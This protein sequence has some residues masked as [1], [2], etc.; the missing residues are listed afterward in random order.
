MK[1]DN[2]FTRS[3]KSK[4][5][6]TNSGEPFLDEYN[7]DG[8]DTLIKTGKTNIYEKIQ[9]AAPAQDINYIVQKFIN[10]DPNAL[11]SVHG[12]YGDFSDMPTTYAELFDR[13]RTC[14]D[15]FNALPI[16]LRNEFD[17]NAYEFWKDFGSDRFNSVVSR[18]VDDTNSD[19]APTEEIVKGEDK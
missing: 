10:G 14:K 8:S 4:E 15:M 18:F 7:Y 3:L 19:I 1:F 5:F 17:N 16:E 9:A 6:I 2:V 12:I 13:V 11:N